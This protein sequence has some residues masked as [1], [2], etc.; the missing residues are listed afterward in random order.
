[1]YVFCFVIWFV[2]LSIW[3]F[4]SLFGH[5][6]FE[7][8]GLGGGALHHQLHHGCHHVIR[9]LRSTR[10]PA[11]GVLIRAILTGATQTIFALDFRV[12][13][14]ALLSIC[15]SWEVLALLTWVNER[16]ILR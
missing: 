4:L 9:V 11:F 2:H 13:V 3:Y 12:K 14:N 7:G 10:H 15:A 16:A 1:M 6:L 8:P 5:F